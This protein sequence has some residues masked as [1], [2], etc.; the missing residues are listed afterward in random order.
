M[1]RSPRPQDISWFLDLHDK[2]QLNL[3][4]PY[5][6][7]SVWS[8]KDKE[9]FIDTIMNNL[10]A[11]PVFLHKTLDDAGKQTFHVVDGKQ[12]IQTIIE[13]RNNKVRLP[14]DFADVNLAKKKWN[15]LPRAQR[16]LFWN[17]EL[18]VEQIADVSDA[19][20]KNIFER[21]NR[22]A[23]KLTNQELRHAKYDGWFIRTAEAEADKQVWRDLGLNTPARMKRMADVQFISELMIVT[24]QSR[25]IG[26]D[27]DAIDDVYAAYEEPSEQPLFVEDDFRAQF[28]QTKSYVRSLFEL[29]KG[30]SDYFKV[31]GHFY[32]LW[33]YLTLE[34]N[35]LLSVDEMLPR[36][37]TFLGD[38][39]QV[40][41]RFQGDDVPQ[42]QDEPEVYQ[43]AVLSY[44]I[45][46]RGAST[47]LAP[48]LARHHDLVAVLHGQEPANNEDQ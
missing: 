41:D 36:Y 12:R 19:A 8:R 43:R 34:K 3:D 33:A 28:D 40:V 25:I 44:A 22:N 32:T 10:P 47:D 48:R 45:N 37:K 27:Q 26:F 11:P 7:R 15:D 31:Q 13:F 24:L 16:E 20:I 9:F 18:V 30:V 2:G 42:I 38:V 46:I 29:D 23:R 4:P 35:R 17:Y 1:A 39:S 6:R 14:E 5:Q 21:I